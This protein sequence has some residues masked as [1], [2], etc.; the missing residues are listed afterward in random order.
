MKNSRPSPVKKLFE[1][2]APKKATSK[3]GRKKAKAVGLQE[4]NPM[5]VEDIQ[6]TEK[7]MEEQVV[8][9]SSPEEESAPV[10]G[11]EPEA[12]PSA[13][14]ISSVLD[15]EYKLYSV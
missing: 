12:S 13:S 15:R 11:I 8:L 4:T 1:D 5:P 6:K 7:A 2:M 10:E 14:P 9:L 3:C